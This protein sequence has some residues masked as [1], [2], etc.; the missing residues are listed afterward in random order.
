MTDDV[1]VRDRLR[2]LRQNATTWILTLSLLVVALLVG[3]AWSAGLFSSSS[4]NARNV[5]SA[6]SMTQVNSAD[7]VAIMGASDLVPG[8]VVE[9]SA[10][11]QSVG[12]ARADFTLTVQD[13]LDE[14]GPGGGLL[15]TRLQ[16]EVFE[17]DLA[18][19]IYSGPLAG[20]DVSLG[21]WAVDEERSYRFVATLPEGP[22]E[23]AD[24]PYQ[25]SKVTATF[26]WQA[27]QAH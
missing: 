7:N 5:V 23:G 1:R 19:P 20:L 18:Q 13:V 6:G 17:S 11:I 9:G 2:V 14:P 26:V 10:T 4:A 16:L 27:V 22:D 24:N 21:T 3:V 8:D 12:D 25:G 15:S